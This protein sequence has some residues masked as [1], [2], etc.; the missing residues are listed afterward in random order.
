MQPGGWRTERSLACCLRLPVGGRW[1]PVD[2]GGNAGVT[3]HSGDFEDGNEGDSVY[4]AAEVL[5]GQIGPAA[6][7]FSLGIVRH[8]VEPN[9]W[10]RVRS[11]DA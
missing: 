10:L 8:N 11:A 3:V 2:G 9:S 4:L 5:D 1:W 6:D 7:I